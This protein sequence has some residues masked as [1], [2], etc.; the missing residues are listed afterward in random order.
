MLKT[1]SITG[2]DKEGIPFKKENITIDHAVTMTGISN[3][4]WI[5][6]VVDDIINETP[7]ILQKIDIKLDSSILLSGYLTSY[8]DIIDTLGIMLPFIVTGSSI[9]QTSPLLIF[10]K[11]DLILTIHDDYG[12]KIKKLHTYSSNLLRKLPQGPNKWDDRQTLLLFRLMDEVS[13]A[14]FS[15]LRFIVEKT[16]QLELDLTNSRQIK[17]DLSLELSNMK[18]SILTFLNAV[19]AIH[20][21]IRNLKYGDS[22]ML[23]DNDDILEK[24]EVILSRLDRQI[25]TAENVMDVI[26]TGM[27]VI[28]TETSNKLTTLIVWLTVVATAVLVPNTL[29]TIFGIPDFAIKYVWIMPI[30]VIST[31]ISTIITYRYTKEWRVNPFKINRLKK[32]RKKFY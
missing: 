3:L 5:E 13:A 14:N 25:Q 29:A 7:S 21:I 22:D 30:L 27:V 17:R 12:G 16:E 9:T 11:K 8:E 1:V 26:S 4:T 20:D 15:V 28:Q 10:M 2:M 6:C 32:L 23:T 24:F 19:W 18:R 31:I